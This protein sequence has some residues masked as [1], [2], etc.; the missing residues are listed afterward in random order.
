MT[1]HDI[2]SAI[3][4][5]KYFTRILEEKHALLTEKG[6]ED[7]DIVSENST[8]SKIKRV[9]GELKDILTKQINRTHPK[10]ERAENIEQRQIR[11]K[12]K[13]APGQG[14]I[15]LDT[16]PPDNGEDKTNT[17][18]TVTEGQFLTESEQ[19]EKDKETS[20]T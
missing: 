13:P 12:N 16:I 14:E 9:A 19:A 15:P 3:G 18:A 6:Y 11:V 4:Y 10:S 1:L 7:A 20:L 2:K 17:S 5:S 8:T